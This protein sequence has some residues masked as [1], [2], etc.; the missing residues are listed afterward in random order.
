[1]MISPRRQ[2]SLPAGDRIGTNTFRN[3]PSLS[4]EERLS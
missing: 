2:E 4:G 1:M 3:M